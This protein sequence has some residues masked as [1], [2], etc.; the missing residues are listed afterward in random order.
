MKY[1]LSVGLNYPGTENELNGCITD[2]NYWMSV[3]SR[4]GFDD[5]SQLVNSKGEKNSI[6]SSLISTLD[7]AKDGDLVAFTYSGHGT[8]VPGGQALVPH[9]F[10]WNDHNTWLTYDEIDNILLSHE[11]RGVVFVA[12]FDACHTQADP[13]KHFRGFNNHKVKNRFLP[14]PDFIKRRTVGDPFERNI[15]TSDQDDLLLSGCQKKQTSA[16]AEIAGNYWGAFTFALSRSLEDYMYGHMN[17]AL[18][19]AKSILEARTWLSENDYDQVPSGDGDPE[20]LN[21]P[22]FSLV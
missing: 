12:L 3:M 11:S 2:S 15:L 18:S 10:S 16:D 8:L 20:I 4:A 19:Y 7:K 21:L 5:V 22:F 13:R 9:N 1:G 14:I 17:K 6:V